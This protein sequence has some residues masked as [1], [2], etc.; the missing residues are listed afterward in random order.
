MDFV[1]RQIFEVDLKA[2]TPPVI[3]IMDED[4]DDRLLLKDAFRECRPDLLIHAFEKAEELMDYLDR[5]EAAGLIVLGLHLPRERTFDI[6]KRTKSNCRLRHIPLI[7]LIGMVPDSVIMKFY[8]LG[9]NT[10]ISRP[11]L[12]DELAAV[13][14]KTSDYWFGPLKI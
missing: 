14:K 9:V 11:V 7:V 1:L 6:I 5:E 10:V 13:L 3:A 8:D 12:W 4:C 2:K